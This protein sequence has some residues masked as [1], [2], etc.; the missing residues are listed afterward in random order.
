LGANKAVC[1]VNV[2]PA[3]SSHVR[4][5]SVALVILIFLLHGKYS[6]LVNEMTSDYSLSRLCTGH[7]AIVVVNMDDPR[8]CRYAEH[9]FG[10]DYLSLLYHL[11][12][13]LGLYGVI[14]SC[15]LSYLTNRS[16]WVL[17]NGVTLSV[18]HSLCLVPKVQSLLCNCLFSSLWILRT[19]LTST[20]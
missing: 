15:F 4:T 20:K 10:I 9:A 2:H 5:I 13:Q 14:L 19:R 16:V 11:E 12:H 7:C 17:L 1:M 3:S 8:S 6:H 18:V